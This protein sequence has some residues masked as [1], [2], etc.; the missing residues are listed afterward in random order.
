M[1]EYTKVN[2]RLSDSQ[3]KKLKH[4]VSNNTGTTLRIS[5]KMLNGNNLP[6]ELLLTTR[7]KTK[8][9]NAFNSNTCTD[10]KL[11]KTQ[12]NKIIQSGG[13]L[14][15]LLGPLLKTGLPLIKV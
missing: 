4:A 11:S 15:R 7:Q 3:I 13:F 2:V 12:I 8:I 5:L 14:D 9:R 1:V 6:H 10:I